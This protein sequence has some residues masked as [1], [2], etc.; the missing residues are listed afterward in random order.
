MNRQERMH[1]L[2]ERTALQRMIAATPPEELIDLRSLNTRLEIVNLQLS[3]SPEDTRQPARARLTFRGRPVVG[4]YGIFAEFGME[5]T[6]AFTDAVAAV[7]ASFTAPLQ[8]MGPIPNRSQNQLLITSTATGSFGFEL[9]EHGP[10]Q[11]TLE[12]DSVLPSALEQ[13]RQFLEGSTGSDDQLAD[14][15]SEI[16][17]RAV[18]AI[19]NFLDKLATNEAVCAV[20]TNEGRFAFSDVG[21]V[22]TAVSRLATENLVEEEIT[23]TGEFQGALPKRRTFEFVRVD[24]GEVLVGKIAPAIRNPDMIN[25]HL[26]QRIELQLVRTKVGAG[27]PRYLLK[28]L[29]QWPRD[30]KSPGG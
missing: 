29:P 24:D 3:D 25:S 22:R 28:E 17:P 10:E 6:M 4:S 30:G 1:L 8:A 16:D 15:A 13:M 18:T 5:A 19:R 9:E 7:A 27:R 21:Q 26:H 20:E 11:L 23:V 2:S 14:V 12:D